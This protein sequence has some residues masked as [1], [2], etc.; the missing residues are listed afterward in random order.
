[1]AN[2]Q[3]SHEKQFDIDGHALQKVKE[4]MAFGDDIKEYKDWED[5]LRCD[6]AK[7]IRV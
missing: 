7:R 4:L 1:V 6:R 5:L 2:L 3:A